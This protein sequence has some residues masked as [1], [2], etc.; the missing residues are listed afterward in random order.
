[1]FGSSSGNPN[2]DTELTGVPAETISSVSWSPKANFIAAGSWDKS[3]RCWE[4]QAS[5]SNVQSVPKAEQT[6]D[7]PILCTDWH[8]VRIYFIFI[9]F[10]HIIPTNSLSLWTGWLEDILG[11][12]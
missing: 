1:M 5:G 6:A 8:D 11:W 2:G 4:V 12:M 7:A 3:V 10:N 9:I